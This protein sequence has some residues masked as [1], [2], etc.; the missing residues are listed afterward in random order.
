[1]VFRNSLYYVDSVDRTGDG[2]SF[3]IRL[4]PDHIIYK[5]H[6]PGEPITP[7]VC[8]LQTGV[9][10]LS[11]AVGCTLEISSVKNVKFLNILHPDS[12]SVYV[13]VHKIETKDGNVK[14]QV[15][16]HTP[17]QSIAKLSLVC[18]TTVK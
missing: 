3:T 5:A 10:L 9:E 2:V 7:G 4:N 1:M 15:D 17:D 14:A 8:I 6:F 13:D 18:Q 12:S 11:E 16:F